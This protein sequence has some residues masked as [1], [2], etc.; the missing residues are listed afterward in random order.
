M[1][2]STTISGLNSIVDTRMGVTTILAVSSGSAIA[3][4]LGTSSPKTIDSTVAT[5]S[6]NKVPIDCATVSPSPIQ[7]RTG[8][9]RSAKAG[10][11]TK[12]S[13][14]VVIVMP[15]CA[16]DNWVDSDRR[17]IINDLAPRSPCAACLAVAARSAVTRLNSAA[18]YRAVPAIRIRP[19]PTMIHCV[20]N[21]VLLPGR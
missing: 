13:A 5:N 7:S 3:M 16:P 11:M 15:I 14:K 4:F 19:T 9:T 10:C 2:L 6:P 18:T 21:S 1:P 8:E 17:P 20:I 12:P